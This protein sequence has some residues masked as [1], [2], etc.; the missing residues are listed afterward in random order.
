MDPKK[1]EKFKKTLQSHRERTRGIRGCTW[2]AF[3]V[4]KK[5]AENN[6]HVDIF[7]DF[8]REILRDIP[9]FTAPKSAVMCRDTLFKM[10][11]DGSHTEAIKKV[12]SNHQVLKGFPEFLLT[13]KGINK[14]KHYCPSWPPQPIPEVKASSKLSRASLAR[15]KSLASPVVNTKVPDLEETIEKSLA[16][17]DQ[18]VKS[19]KPDLI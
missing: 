15:R 14:G 19:V 3:D 1:E 13:L 6:W 7:A 5:A 11:I 2:P 12:I 4:L 18:L 10:L 17:R 16:E 8:C 9:N